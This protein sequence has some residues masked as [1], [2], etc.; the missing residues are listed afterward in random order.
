M[1][2]S[3]EPDPVPFWVSVLVAAAIVAALAAAA[4]WL[5]SIPSFP[6]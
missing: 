2:P 3:T 1:K 4:R 5:P 6:F